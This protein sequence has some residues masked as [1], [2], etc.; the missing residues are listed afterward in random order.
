MGGNEWPWACLVVLDNEPDFTI[1][2]HD[3]EY[4]QRLRFPEKNEDL[5]KKAGLGVKMK[6]G[7]KDLGPDILKVLLWVLA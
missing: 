2:P 3:E 6:F 5:F 1:C 4:N 7:P